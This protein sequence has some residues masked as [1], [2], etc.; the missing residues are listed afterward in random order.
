MQLL[1]F[2]ITGTGAT[3]AL[4]SAA[5]GIP[6]QCKWFQFLNVDAAVLTI[7]GSS[8]DATHGYPITGTA[9]NFQP[10]VAEEFN[11]YDLEAIFFFMTTSG[12]GVLMCAV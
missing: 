3:L 10:P 6:K 1:S 7:G 2:N 11:F 9:A 5:L 8:V 12:N 4:A